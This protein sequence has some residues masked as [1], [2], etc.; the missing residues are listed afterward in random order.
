MKNVILIMGI[1]LW[2]SPAHASLSC[3]QFTHA[4]QKIEITNDGWKQG[5][6][7]IS[8]WETI[9]MTISFVKGH[10]DGMQNAMRLTDYAN[11]LKF[12]ENQKSI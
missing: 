8:E 12:A 5:L 9:I 10:R 7:S 1:L 4:Y 11:N 3:I 6:A 2:F